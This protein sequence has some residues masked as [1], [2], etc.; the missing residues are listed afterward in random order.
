MNKKPVV[1]ITTFIHPTSTI[2]GNVTIGKFCG[3]F[4]QAVIRGDQNSITIGNGS[5]IQDCCIIHTNELHKVTIGENV[6]I[7]HAAMVHGATIED[8]C[9]IGICESSPIFTYF[10]RAPARAYFSAKRLP[11]CSIRINWTSA[12]VICWPAPFGRLQFLR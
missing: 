10:I 11:L 4:P 8:N 2:I 12:A 3:V 7:G 5:N 6:S 9:I 1:D